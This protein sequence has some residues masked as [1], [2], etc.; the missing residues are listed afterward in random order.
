MSEAAYKETVL[1]FHYQITYLVKKH[2]IP[3]ELIVTID[4]SPSKYIESTKNTMAVKGSKHVAISHSS[5]KRSITITIGISLDGT[6]LPYQLIYA[7]KTPRCLPDRRLLPENFLLSF[8]PT[9]WSNEVETTKLLQSVLGP[10]FDSTKKRLNLPR[11]Q[12]S[13]LI[14]D[15][16]RAHHCPSVKSLADV[17]SIVTADIPKNFTHLVSPLDFTVNK[18]MKTLEQDDFAD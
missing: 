15:D 1:K 18:K 6:I 3:D 9:H 12:K 8:N 17:M 7:G 4:Q 16:F 5:D 13:L 14:W 2:Q 10:Y 11:A